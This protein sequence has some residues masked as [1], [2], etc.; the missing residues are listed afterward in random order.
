MGRK[1]STSLEVSTMLF[2][3]VSEPAALTTLSLPL[4]WWGAR[5]TCL[6]VVESGNTCT[7]V[8]ASAPAQ[9]L[10]QQTDIWVGV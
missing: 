2:P 9:L 5:G 6:P 1:M 4:Q 8:L 10:F 7:E 3:P